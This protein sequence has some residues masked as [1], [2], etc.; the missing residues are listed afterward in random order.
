MSEKSEHA[1]S[2]GKP[3]PGQPQLCAD[4]QRLLDGLIEAG[5]DLAQM[6][7]LSAADRAR[8]ERVLRLMGLMNDYPVDDADDALLDVTMARIDRCEHERAAR[9]SV[10]P[11]EPSSRGGLSFRLPDFISVAAVMLIAASI[12]LPLLSSVRQQSID[13]NC[14][15]NM[16][17]VGYAFGHYA[18]DN[19]GAMPMARAGFLPGAS[20]D[21][22]SNVVN[23]AP[24]VEGQYCGLGHLNC[25]GNHD[26]LEN[27]YS[28]QWQKPGTQMMWGHGRV[29][30]I[31]GDRN[32]LIDAAH[33]G[34]MLPATTL[35]RDHG[36]RGQN[37]LASDG[38]TLWLTNTI[39][40]T[41]DNIWL[42]H[43]AQELSAGATPK[44]Q[45]DVMLAH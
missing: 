28:Y 13:R 31:L 7:P 41:R 14:Q 36:G 39:V 5:F 32:P 44:D 45:S 24:L 3:T 12:L 40:G 1:G 20:W 16:R 11:E 15:N 35:S 2:G 27:T 29:S 10:S 17:M 25:A 6:G 18:A 34:R 19:N 30:I 22:V 37:V 4:D 38:A 42:P 26:H 21:T 33:Q 23:L 8:A 9:M 43:G